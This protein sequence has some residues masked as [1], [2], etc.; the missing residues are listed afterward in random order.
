[1]AAM[2]PF[3]R[4]CPTVAGL[5]FTVGTV[6]Q[7]TP[8]KEVP[9]IVLH[10]DSSLKAVVGI[11]MQNRFTYQHTA[12]A[13]QEADAADFQVRRFRLRL[14]GHAITPRL[15]YKV[16]LGLSDRDVSI[17]DGTGATSLLMDAMVFY[18][19]GKN[20][21]L[22]F[23]QGKLPGGRLAL[24]SSAAMEL[25]E[26]AL[27]N[28]AFTAERDRGI[29]LEQAIPAGRQAVHAHL[30]V[31]Q[32][33]GRSGQRG[34]PG[35]CYT[36]RLEWMPFGVFRQN[37]AYSEGDFYREPSPKLA[38]AAAYSTDR[39]ALRARAQNGPLLPD[40]QARTIGTFYADAM[41]KC[42][43]WAWLGEFDRRLADGDPWASDTAKHVSVA[44]NEGWAITNQASRMVGKHSQVAVRHSMV[45]YDAAV[46]SAFSDRDEVLLGWSY[47]LIDH[48][49]K[50]Q[51]AVL[52][53]WGEGNAN[54]NHVGNQVGFMFQV[55]FGI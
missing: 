40:G 22:G 51:S 44:V 55:E 12:G 50:L 16:Q 2:L 3:A 27:A 52:Y 31:S 14:D 17:G 54:I 13:G 47:F 11:R 9:S 5:A 39:N 15:Q 25:P 36:S 32:G 21:R 30:A 48:R 26:R 46:H 29:Q 43:G 4:I 8:I 6:A 18:Q 28:G 20:T 35:L 7:S 33:E 19:A 53:E 1:M 10:N 49:I 24:I 37:G 23:G 38:I 41:F 34:T 42:K 45:R